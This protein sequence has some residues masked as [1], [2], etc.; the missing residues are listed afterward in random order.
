VHDDGAAREAMVD[1]L[2]YSVEEIAQATGTCRDGLYAAIR[3]GRLRAKKYGARTLILRA[4][5]E[6]FLQS[7]PDLD[8]PPEEPRKRKVA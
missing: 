7:L 2:A 3:D 4:D 8:L 1:R 6:A 5:A